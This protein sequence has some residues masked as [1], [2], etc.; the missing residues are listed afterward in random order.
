MLSCRK[1]K[2]RKKKNKEQI[3]TGMIRW[4]SW[5]I[6][7]SKF[8]A[9]CDMS[10][11]LEAVHFLLFSWFLYNHSIFFFILWNSPWKVGSINL[12]SREEFLENIIVEIF[13]CGFMC[14]ENLVKIKIYLKKISEKK[15]Q[16]WDLRIAY[17]THQQ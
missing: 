16:L 11:E 9:G 15:C 8:I 17:F 3:E 5:D 1:G 13:F 6:E 7:W 2:A 4:A 10:K 12:V 14:G